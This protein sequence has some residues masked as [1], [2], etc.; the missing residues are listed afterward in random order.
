MITRF[1][2][3][4]ERIA[5]RV[6]CT[7]AR[8]SDRRIVNYNR[9]E[10]G[11]VSNDA[12]RRRPV[13][14]RA[15]IGSSY[16]NLGNMKKN[17]GYENI[18]ARARPRSSLPKYYA[19]YESVFFYKKYIASQK[20]ERTVNKN[21]IHSNRLSFLHNVPFSQNYATEKERTGIL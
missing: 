4:A 15:S 2:R 5:N 17:V 13:M 11:A 21:K 16:R 9:R 6:A 18:C 14:R 8:I 19:E 12:V 20:Q 7:Y 3:I 10:S 1:L